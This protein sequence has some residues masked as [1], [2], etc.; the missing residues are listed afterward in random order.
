MS[1]HA[2]LSAS[3]SARWINCPGSVRMEDGSYQTLTLSS[4][5]GLRVGD[6]VRL[7]NGNLQRY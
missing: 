3:G 2:K 6:R 5:S 1:A 4:T 7:E